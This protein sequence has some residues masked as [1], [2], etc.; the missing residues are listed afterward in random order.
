MNGILAYHYVADNHH[1]IP[2][3]ST[4]RRSM[5]SLFGMV[6]TRSTTVPASRPRWWRRLDQWLLEAVLALF[7]LLVAGFCGWQVLSVTTFSLLEVDTVLDPSNVIVSGG[8]AGR[9]SALG[10]TSGRL[11]IEDPDVVERFWAAAPWGLL[12]AA[13][14]LAWWQVWRVLATLRGTDPFTPRNGRRMLSAAGIVLVAAVVAG[15][16]HGV[17]TQAWTSEAQRA[18]LA[19]EQGPVQP[20]PDLLLAPFAAGLCLLTA[21]L[22]FRRA[23]AIREDLI[24]LV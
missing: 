4:Y 24:G 6:E 1:W 3:R 15:I 8:S 5:V 17:T 10:T 9:F 7:I 19:V 13:A 20:G 18:F 21:A 11:L 12:A 2:D 23:V 14:L 22:F 16:V